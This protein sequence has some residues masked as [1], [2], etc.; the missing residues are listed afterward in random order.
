MAWQEF[1]KRI[2]KVAS[3][4]WG[5]NAS[6]ET[7]AGVKC[8]CV[9]KVQPDYYV[10]VEITEEKSL[11]KVRTDIAKLWTVKHAFMEQNIYCQ[12]YM[13]MEKDPTDAMRAAGDASK[14]SVLSGR[15]FQNQYFDYGSYVYVRKGH[16]F[17][18]LIDT[19]T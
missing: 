1:E 18:S 3:Y 17:G 11:E 13:V 4:R 16:P 14:I 5:C 6:T 12:F 15:E 19:E 9:L 8:D 2:R 10:L 7:I